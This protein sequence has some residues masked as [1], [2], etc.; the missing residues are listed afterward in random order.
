MFNQTGIDQL[1]S[2]LSFSPPGTLHEDFASLTIH[3]WEELW[4]AAAAH[5][6]SPLVYYQLSNL[7]VLPD[8]PPSIAT[9]FR[10]A[11][12]HSTRRSTISF[13]Q[14]GQVLETLNSAGIPVIVLKGA[15]LAELVYDDPA[16]RPMADFDLLV[17]Q[18]DLHLVD[19]TMISCGYGPTQSEWIDKGYIDS[20]QHVPLYSQTNAHPFE[21]HWTITHP[22]NPI[23]INLDILWE[24]VGSATIAGEK[25]LV[26]S[27]E[28]LLLHLCLHACQD[29]LYSSGL[30]SIIDVSVTI[31]RYLSDLDWQQVIRFSQQW[32]AVKPVYLTLFLARDLV[33]SPVPDQVLAALEPHDITPQVIQSAVEKILTDQKLSRHFS[34]I[35]DSGPI[36]KNVLRVFTRIFLSPG[37]MSRKY[38][39]TPGSPIIYWH[40]L[41]RMKILLGRYRH[42][43]WQMLR[44]DEE[45]S[46]FVNQ[47]NCLTDWL[48]A[49]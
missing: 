28:D 11:L 18:E 26:L 41:R 48:A 37:D 20:H 32:G 1:L 24:Q 47:Q 25:V 45:T 9:K 43:S 10:N 17:H 39:I 33:C 16:L 7:G 44:G 19:K 13:H 4:R 5:G 12:H 40:Y 30:R 27:P 8:V 15:H 21:I 6:L 29:S 22:S 31:E 2:L 34:R 3:D 42:H 38:N 46:T 36:H 49:P 35:W 23:S 14:L